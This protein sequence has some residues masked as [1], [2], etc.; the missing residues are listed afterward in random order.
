MKQK[1]LIFLNSGIP[2]NIIRGAILC[3]VSEYDP[4]YPLWKNKL[5]K[6]LAKELVDK[7]LEKNI[8]DACL[9][10]INEKF[11]EYSVSRVAISFQKAIN[12]KKAYIELFFKIKLLK[13]NIPDIIKGVNIFYSENGEKISKFLKS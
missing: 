7:Y 11:V 5:T 3:Y 4:I 10:H 12:T 13:Q 8:I 6:E 1:K 2:G 9:N